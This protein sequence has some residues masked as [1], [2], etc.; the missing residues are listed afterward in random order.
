[1]SAQIKQFGSVCSIMAYLKGRDV[2]KNVLKK[3]V[4]AIS[5]GS[6]DIFGYFESRSTVNPAVFI[7]SLMTAYESHINVRFFPRAM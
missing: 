6:N 4:I 3:S 5:V 1:M 2:A 7:N